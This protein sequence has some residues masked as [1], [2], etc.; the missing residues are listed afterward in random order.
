MPVEEPTPPS[1]SSSASL[2]GRKVSHYRVLEFVGD[3]GIGIVYKAEDIKLA[4]RVALKFLPE[5][6]SGNQHALE[7]CLSRPRPWLR[8]Y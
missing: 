2:I 6:L 1:V 5:E 4:R 3:G 8:G 7:R